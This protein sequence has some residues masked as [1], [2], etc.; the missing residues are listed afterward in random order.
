VA[1]LDVSSRTSVGWQRC[2]NATVEQVQQAWDQALSNEGLLADTTH[3]LGLE[4]LSDHGSQMT[5]HSM[6]E[7]FQ[8]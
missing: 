3:P 5:A 6:A 4:A 8:T 1:I 2:L 7:C